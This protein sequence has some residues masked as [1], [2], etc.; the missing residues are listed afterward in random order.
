MTI[1]QNLLIQENFQRALKQCCAVVF[2]KHQVLLL[3]VMDPAELEFPF[4][5]IL[6]FV[7]M[8]TKEK[9]QVD[10]K[11]IREAYIKEVSAFVENFRKECGDRN[12][13]YRLTRTDE[14]YERMLL[15]Y[16]AT[17]KAMMR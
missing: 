15:T 12:I 13:E 1:C 7:D 3:H 4:K 10:P 14:P 6:S 11:F 2:K 9:L 5:K 16:L 17:R 8:E